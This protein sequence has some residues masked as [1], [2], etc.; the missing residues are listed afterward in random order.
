M[1]S[2]ITVPSPSRMY[3]IT[4]VGDVASFAQKAFAADKTISARDRAVLLGLIKTH[5]HLIGAYLK[6]VT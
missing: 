1:A 3:R 4:H 6:G 2:L 5:I